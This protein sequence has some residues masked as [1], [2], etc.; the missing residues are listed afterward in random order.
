VIVV[1]GGI[2]LTRP[3]TR[4]PGQ[5]SVT[6]KASVQEYDRL[7]EKNNQ[8]DAEPAIQQAHEAKAPA[9]V[10]DNARDKLARNS[11]RAVRPAEKHM[12]AHMQP[13]MMFD[14]TDQVQTAPAPL[15]KADSTRLDAPIARGQVFGASNEGGTNAAQPAR[16]KDAGA[17][18]NTVEVAS[19]A[20]EEKSK[21]A[22]FSQ[23]QKA[24]DTLAESGGISNEQQEREIRAKKSP[25]H[26]A[27]MASAR[28][29]LPRWIVTSDG[30][31]QRSFDSGNTW[32]SVSIENSKG[33]FRAVFYSGTDVWAGGKAGLL[34]HSSDAG[35]N[36]KQITPSWDGGR[37]RSDIV[38]IDFSN[39]QHGS[40]NTADGDIWITADG[41]QT[42]RKQ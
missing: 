18:M 23:A 25:M 40:V 5:K 21:A 42:W 15:A 28:T 10:R 6:S 37:L 12:T 19:A 3:G 14:N 29:P 13:P 7:A 27:S 32:Q 26:A 30:A 22:D 39:L 38:R 1:A 20:P 17:D 2:F 16:P 4:L 41:G 8:P 36:W 33:E 31:L 35:Q 24:K 11:V 9:P 34:Y